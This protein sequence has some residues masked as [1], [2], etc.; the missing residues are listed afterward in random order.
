MVGIEG[1][2]ASMIGIG[3]VCVSDIVDYAMGRVG[4]KGE[5]ARRVRFYDFVSMTCL[6]YK[7]IVRIRV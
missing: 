5:W 4:E 2:W 3:L 1:E 7:Y 6:Y